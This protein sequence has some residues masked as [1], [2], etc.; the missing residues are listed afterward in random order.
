MTNQVTTAPVH[1]GP[2]QTEQDS[3]GIVPAKSWPTVFA[4]ETYWPAGGL[5][6]VGGSLGTLRD[7]RSHFEY[8]GW[9]G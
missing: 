8:P 3:F 6:A 7:S 2:S 4:L 5:A 9:P 1:V